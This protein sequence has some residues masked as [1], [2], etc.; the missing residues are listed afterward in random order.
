MG[1]IGRYLLM[2]TM[3]TRQVRFVEHEN[4]VKNALGDEGMRVIEM[5]G[6]GKEIKSTRT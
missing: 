4:N 1:D 2:S 6:I 3:R 5:V